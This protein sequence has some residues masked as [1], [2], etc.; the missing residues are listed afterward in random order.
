MHNC[1]LGCTPSSHSRTKESR[2]RIVAIQSWSA[3]SR[4]TMAATV[5][6]AA[7]VRVR[8]AAVKAM[9]AEA[10]SEAR[11]RCNR[12]PCAR[13]T[14]HSQRQGQAWATKGCWVLVT[15]STSNLAANG[16]GGVEGV[17]Q[18]AARALGAR[19]SI[20]TPVANASTGRAR[21]V[22]KLSAR[23]MQHEHP[24]ARKESC[25]SVA[26][27]GY[28]GANIRLRAVIVPSHLG[29]P[30]ADSNHRRNGRQHAC[31]Q[32]LLHRKG[33]LSFVTA[34]TPRGAF[35]R[36]C[37]EQTL[38]WDP[39]SNCTKADMTIDE[40]RPPPVAMAVAALRAARSHSVA[41]LA[42]A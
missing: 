6:A 36:F 41:R 34:G 13:N 15:C 5:V 40:A 29:A 30:T 24:C 19:P 35:Y 3:R 38:R 25:S 31:A 33:N 7:A 27:R 18:I 16:A 32:A 9:A 21:V 2:Q 12:C 23:A 39:R 42:G 26:S 11:N 1:G 8:G 17:A 20:C 4:H 10:R 37:G 14:R 22:A 28:G